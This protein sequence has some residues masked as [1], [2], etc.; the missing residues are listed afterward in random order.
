MISA[1]LKRDILY[2]WR[3]PENTIPSIAKAYGCT[4]DEIER[5]VFPNRNIGWRAGRGG[6]GRVVP[7][8]PRPSGMPVMRKEEKKE[9]LKMIMEGLALIQEGIKLMKDEG[10]HIKI[11]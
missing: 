4:I 11:G 8:P 1:Q 9:P 2:S 5:I 6:S 7:L 10:I 3:Q